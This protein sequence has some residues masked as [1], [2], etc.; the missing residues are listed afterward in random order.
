VLN[1][2]ICSNAWNRPMQIKCI[3]MYLASDVHSYL[4]SPRVNVAKERKINENG[5]RSRVNTMVVSGVIEKIQH[6]S[7]H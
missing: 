2:I 6:S 3:K 1:G 4:F 5:K 7:M